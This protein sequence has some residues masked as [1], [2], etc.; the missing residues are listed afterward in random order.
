MSSKIRVLPHVQ[1]PRGDREKK[2]RLRSAHLQRGTR[3]RLSAF[4][5]SCSVAEETHEP[6]RNRCVSRSKRFPQNDHRHPNSSPLLQQLLAFSKRAVKS[7]RT[8]ICLHSGA[9]NRGPFPRA[10]ESLNAPEILLL[11]L[12]LQTGA[13]R[14]LSFTFVLSPTWRTMCFSGSRLRLSSAQLVPSVTGTPF[15]NLLAAS[16]LSSSLAESQSNALVRRR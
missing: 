2:L 4:Q 7:R 16:R 5:R 8:L 10:A 6:P 14:H 15:L 1:L 13:R 12:L 11:L 3:A 9:Y